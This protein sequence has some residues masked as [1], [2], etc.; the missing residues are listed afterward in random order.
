MLI[1]VNTKKQIDLFLSKPANALVI[2]SPVR[3]SG[4][5]LASILIR[6][7][8]G[9]SEDYILD[10]HPY[11]YR[12]V[13]DKD[14]VKIDSIRSLLKKL[15][16][17]SLSPNTISR[18]SLIEDAELMSEESQNSILKLL[19]EPPLDTV[20][21]LLTKSFSSLNS[22]ILSRSAQIKIVKPSYNEFVNYYSNNKLSGELKNKFDFAGGNSDYYIKYINEDVDLSKNL[23]IILIKKFLAGN[24]LERLLMINDFCNSK[25]TFENLLFSLKNIIKI[26]LDNSIKRKSTQTKMWLFYLKAVEKTETGL[27]NSVNRKLLFTNL[28]LNM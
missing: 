12:I 3:G 26:G 25:Q 11:F 10:N 8:L 1:A 17:K 18:V 16:L 14:T 13:R 28:C 27:A 9:L 23:D 6:Q 20:I 7:L 22:T 24:R 5:E 21:I 19:E 4:Q 2:E 15:K